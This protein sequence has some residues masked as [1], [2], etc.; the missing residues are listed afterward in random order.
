MALVQLNL[1]TAFGARNTQIHLARKKLLGDF[2]L[3][4]HTGLYL[5]VMHLLEFMLRFLIFGIQC[6]SDV[7]SG[8][9]HEN[10]SEASAFTSST[11]SLPRSGLRPAKITW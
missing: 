2:R 3:Q 6:H 8:W 5:Q 1:L 9:R 4:C 11:A 10:F 7:F